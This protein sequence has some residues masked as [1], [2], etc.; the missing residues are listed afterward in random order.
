MIVLKER[1]DYLDKKSGGDGLVGWIIRIFSKTARDADKGRHGE[2]TVINLLQSLDDS[3]YLIN[4]VILP[5]SKGNIDHILLTPKG[6]FA[7]ETKNWDGK[8]ICKGDE[9]KRHYKKGIFPARIL[10]GKAPANRSKVMLLI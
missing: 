4:D 6:I 10:K 2:D 7:I 5:P 3:N 9:W 8:F 1:G